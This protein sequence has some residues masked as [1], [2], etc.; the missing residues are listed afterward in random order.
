MNRKL[1]AA[2]VSAVVGLGLAGWSGPGAARPLGSTGSLNSL[3]SLGSGSIFQQLGG[4]GKVSSLASEF[5]N[6]SLKDPLIARLTA[7]KTVNPATTSGQVSQQLCA[8]L[9]GG[10]QAPL[11]NAQVASAAGKV[12]PGQASAISQ[13]FSSSLRR[14]VSNPVVR[15]AVM[16]VLGSK[17]PGVLAGFL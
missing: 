15:A 8:M 14:I 10:C 4:M 7:G 9:G 17:L 2:G 5:V 3:M 6:S 11:T 13:H 16:K 12:S 1:I